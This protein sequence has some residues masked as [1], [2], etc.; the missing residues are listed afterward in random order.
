MSGEDADLLLDLHQLVKARGDAE[1]TLRTFCELRRRLERRHYVAFYRLRRWLEAHV[2][3]E[4]TAPPGKGQVSLPLRLGFYCV[5][6]VRRACLCRAL[7]QG[8]AGRRLGLAFRYRTL[9]P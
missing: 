1:A 7:D 4:V 8:L 6:A 2:V 3:A 9:P 5:E